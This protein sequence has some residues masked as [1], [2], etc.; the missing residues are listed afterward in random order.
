ME[1]FLDSISDWVP[2][3]DSRITLAPAVSNYDSST[4]SFT[5]SSSTMTAAQESLVIPS[6]SWNIR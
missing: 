6:T 1:V 2:Y 5:V 4:G 3:D